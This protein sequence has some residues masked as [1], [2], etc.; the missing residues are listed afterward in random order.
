[1][2]RT[3][4]IVRTPVLLLAVLMLLLMTAC[5]KTEATTDT[6]KALAESKGYLTQDVMEQFADYGDIVKEA[7]VAAPQSI[8]FKLEFYVLAD[9]SAAGD[10]FANNQ[11]TLESNQAGIYSQ[12]SINLGNHQSYSLT[13]SGKYM[14]I[15]R[16]GKTVLIIFPTDSSNKKEIEAFIKELKY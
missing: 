8:A 7:T 14:F 3:L 16:V 11:A 1:M 12:T 6:F 2:K 15:E 10:F 4:K 5:S 13:A 9:E